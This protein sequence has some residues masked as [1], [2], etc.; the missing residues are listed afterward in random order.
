MRKVLVS[1]ALLAASA[2]PPALAQ[3]AAAQRAISYAD[4]DLA[5]RAGRAQLDRRLAAAVESLCGSYASAASSE[6]REI[7]RCRAAAR[8][9]IARQLAALPPPNPRFALRSH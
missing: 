5:G 7:D 6:T 3:A 2:A 8:T 4:L 1:A 9:G